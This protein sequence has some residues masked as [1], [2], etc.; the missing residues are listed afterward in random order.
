MNQKSQFSYNRQHRV[1]IA[2]S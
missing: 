1:F 2:L